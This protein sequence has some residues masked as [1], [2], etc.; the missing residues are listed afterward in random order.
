MKGEKTNGHMQVANRHC[1]ATYMF[2]EQE[3]VVWFL[4]GC[5]AFFRLL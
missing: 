3:E 2:M 1:V 5:H 4:I